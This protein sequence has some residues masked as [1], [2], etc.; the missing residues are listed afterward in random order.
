MSRRYRVVWETSMPS[1]SICLA[2][3]GP[4]FLSISRIRSFDGFL[5]HSWMSARSS[6]IWYSTPGQ[7][8]NVFK[9]GIFFPEEYFQVG[10]WPGD[11]PRL[12][13]C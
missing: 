13:W 7:V 1:A 2:V 5:V 12:R 8:F 3:I 6:A 10:M 4:F 11:V 9:M